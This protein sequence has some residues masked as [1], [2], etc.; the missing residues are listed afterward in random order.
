MN[1][2]DDAYHQHTTNRWVPVAIM[3]FSNMT[4]LGH[5]HY[6]FEP[7][8]QVSFECKAGIISSPVLQAK[9][10]EGESKASSVIS[11]RSSSW[12]DTADHAPLLHAQIQAPLHNA[13]HKS[14]AMDTLAFQWL[15]L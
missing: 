13:M 12:Y 10:L 2:V 14:T 5:D 8:A 6:Q 1:I 3:G 7:L 4:T 11:I 15:T 9:G